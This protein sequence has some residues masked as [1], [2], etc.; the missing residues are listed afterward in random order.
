MMTKPAD[1][2]TSDMEKTRRAR[3]AFFVGLFDMSWRLGAGMLAPLFIGLFIDSRMAGEGQA[4][5]ILGF[6]IGMGVGVIIIRQ[7]VRKLSDN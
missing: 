4:F 6:I 3:R 2:S 7:I 1:I 5:A